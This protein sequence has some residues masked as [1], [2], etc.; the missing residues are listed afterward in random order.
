MARG[1]FNLNWPFTWLLRNT[2]P[3]TYEVE[4]RVV[5]TV[6]VGDHDPLIRTYRESHTMVA[7]TNNMYLP[8]YRRDGALNPGAQPSISTRGARRWLG[9]ELDTDT[10]LAATM[11]ILGAVV[12]DGFPSYSFYF[13]SGNT[14]WDAGD[15]IPIMG[16]SISFGQ[17]DPDVSRGFGKMASS[18][19]IPD[20]LSI[21]LT[22]LN[23]VGGEVITISGAFLES[24][25][26]SQPL[27][28]MWS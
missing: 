2:T 4:Q 20:P 17:T 15:L 28:S 23:Q 21:V 26:R 13:L 18:L 24:Q 1:L 11:D 5:P 25:D 10:D 6:S 22:I 27:P 7:G 19:Y 3:G 12:G 14:L 9:V 16:A 8:G